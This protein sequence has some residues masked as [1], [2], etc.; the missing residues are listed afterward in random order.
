MPTIIGQGATSLRNSAV[1]VQLFRAGD[2]PAAGEQH[3]KNQKEVGRDA[4]RESDQ[5]A[6]R[7][8]HRAQYAVRLHLLTRGPVDI[9]AGSDEH[10]SRRASVIPRQRPVAS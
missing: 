8:S 1:S 9:S 3:H 4:S 2:G 5:Q 6:W 10:R 7:E